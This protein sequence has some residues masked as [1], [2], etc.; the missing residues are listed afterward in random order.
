MCFRNELD[1]IDCIVQVKTTMPAATAQ[2]TRLGV[3]LKF[4]RQD[5]IS[6]EVLYKRF[7]GEKFR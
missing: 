7:E 2:V 5:D 4:A 6:G 3:Q 1:R